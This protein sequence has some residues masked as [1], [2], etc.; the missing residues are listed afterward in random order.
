MWSAS[1]L[2]IVLPAR[3]TGLAEGAGTQRSRTLWAAVTT[4][5]VAFAAATVAVLPYFAELMAIVASLGDVMSM[6]GLPC[7]FALKLLKLNRAEAAAC[8]VLAVVAVL[9]SGAGLASSV[10]QL[11]VAVK[12]GG[13]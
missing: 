9:L 10:Q 5:C 4:G 6:F 7:L 13:A 2:H 8:C 12:G 11:V 1:L 3:A